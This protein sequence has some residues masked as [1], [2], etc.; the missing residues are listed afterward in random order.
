MGA[1][2][3]RDTGFPPK[4]ERYQCCEASPHGPGTLRTAVGTL[5]V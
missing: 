5:N 4:R 1:F 2:L 3:R